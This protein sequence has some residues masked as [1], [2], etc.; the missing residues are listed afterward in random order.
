MKHALKAI[1][2]AGALGVGGILAAP[3][4]DAHDRRSSVTIYVDLGDVSIAYRNGYYDHHRR[5]HRWRSDDEWRYF[6]RHYR[7]HYH[8]YDYD[9]RR[10]RGRHRGWRRGRG[11]RHWDD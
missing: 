3:S 4:A 2:I 9:W 8:D 11:H 6:R 5:W 7:S 1:M 10:D